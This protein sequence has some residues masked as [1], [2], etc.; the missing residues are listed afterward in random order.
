MTRR[1]CSETKAY[2]LLNVIG[3]GSFGEVYRGQDEA[4]NLVAVKVLC[5]SIF[6]KRMNCFRNEIHALSALKDSGMTPKI[7]DWGFLPE[8]AQL[9]LVMEHLDS[10]LETYLCEIDNKYSFSY[11]CVYACM[12]VTLK[13]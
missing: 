11:H 2:T 4:N 6:K 13:K 9:F 8:K 12:C 3:R 10:D 5:Y 7:F 1:I